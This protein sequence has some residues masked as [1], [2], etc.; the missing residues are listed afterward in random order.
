MAGLSQPRE[1]SRRLGYL[2]RDGRSAGGTRGLAGQSTR[3]ASSPSTGWMHP[4]SSR[5]STAWKKLPEISH[6]RTMRAG[7]RPW[8][9]TWLYALLVYP[10]VEFRGPV[11]HDDVRPAV[12][13]GGRAGS[14]RRTLGGAHSASVTRGLGVVELRGDVELSCVSAVSSGSAGGSASSR[15]DQRRR[16]PESVASPPAGARSRRTRERGRW[17]LLS[18]RV[19]PTGPRWRHRRC[20][21]P[22][23]AAGRRG[24]L[25][26]APPAPC[27]RQGRAALPRNPVASETLSGFTSARPARTARTTVTACRCERRNSPHGILHR[28]DIPNPSRLW[29]PIRRCSRTSWGSWRAAT[30]RG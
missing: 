28:P 21:S 9:A 4:T 18:G 19:D 11:A 22:S 25:R 10:A 15:Q 12:A 5:P 23:T 20:R 24:S 17:P 27:R 16:G 2:G 3:K 29:Q 14:D 6:A 1:G 8:I 13:P 7:A 30:G 26:S